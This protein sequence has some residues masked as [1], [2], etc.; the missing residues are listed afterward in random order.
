MAAQPFAIV[1][2]LGRFQRLIAIAFAC[3]RKNDRL[4]YGSP[5]GPLIMGEIRGGHV[6]GLPM[7][8]LELSQPGIAA[9]QRGY[10]RSAHN[11]R[12]EEHTSELQSLMR[13]SYAVF[14][15][16]KKKTRKQQ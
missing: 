4:K 1:K 10:F 12:S 14:C 6:P 13:I 3:R 9:E 15:L 16:N 8:K 5:K 7:P 11:G 2:A